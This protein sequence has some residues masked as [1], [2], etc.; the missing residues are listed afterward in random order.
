M[1]NHDDGLRGGGGGGEQEFEKKWEQIIF[2]AD[3]HRG[4]R[5]FRCLPMYLTTV[6]FDIRIGKN[7]SYDSSETGAIILITTSCLVFLMSIF[8]RVDTGYSPDIHTSHTQ[9]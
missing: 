5:W 3:Q 7:L 1:V 6:T 9:I 8:Q 4:V 2:H